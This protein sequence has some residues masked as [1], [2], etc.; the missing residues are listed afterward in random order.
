M[1]FKI[2][3]MAL[4][5]MMILPTL[6][7][8]DK[9]DD[10]SEID[11]PKIDGT[12]TDKSNTG[13]PITEKIIDSDDYAYIQSKSEKRGVGFGWQNQ[14]DIDLL[15][16][17]ISWSYNWG[18]TYPTFAERYDLYGL[19]FSPMCWNDNYQDATI[20][21]LFSSHSNIKY[22]LGYNEP[23][24]TDQANMT[25][26][27]AASFWPRFKA[28]G[29]SV[30]A[31]L[32]SPAMNWGT[33]PGWSNGVE[34]LKSFFAQEG[35]SVDDVDAIAVHIY[36]T[37]PQAVIGDLARYKT[38]GKKL[39]LTEFCSWNNGSNPSASGT[40]ISFMSQVLN[41][42]EQDEDI[43]RYAW[44]IARGNYAQDA[45]GMYLLEVTENKLTD[46]GKVYVNMSSF[47]K[48]AIYP[49]GK[50]IPA[51]H[52]RQ[53]SVTDS[54][55]VEI[56]VSTDVDGKLQLAGFSNSYYTDYKIKMGGQNAKIQMRYATNRNNTIMGVYTVN[57]ETNE[58]TLLTAVELPSTGDTKT[59][60][61]AESENITLPIGN[62]V[63]RLRPL[64]GM[65]RLNW[66]KITQ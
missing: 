58:E 49:L 28:L 33:L 65:L 48:N 62:V 29:Q 18:T 42:I 40:Q 50:R 6:Q 57:E 15:A 25:P 36:M 52:Y 32:V 26:T 20:K 7:S 12:E 23:N 30:N 16:P 66:F 5:A 3:S 51:E 41:S 61:T 34:W 63:V 64:N 22:L 47:D 8:C 55:S 53:C 14:T 17:G 19:D 31:K 56:E 54:K 11:E 35:V 44:F 46:L 21:S 10:S 24:L 27:Q 4:I 1:S 38:F 60:A 9:D 13:D 45:R 37:D 39:W 59:W 2:Y 43:E